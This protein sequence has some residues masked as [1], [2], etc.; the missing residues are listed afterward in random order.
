[1]D[2][3]IDPAG[4]VSETGQTER[5]KPGVDLFEVFETS[6]DVIEVDPLGHDRFRALRNDGPLRGLVELRIG[7]DPANLR[8]LTT[9]RGG[10]ADHVDRNFQ[11]AAEIRALVESVD[12]VA[13]LVADD[14]DHHVA[15]A[16]TGQPIDFPQFL[17]IGRRLED[18]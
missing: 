9:E 8:L 5:T 4:F 15:F 7:V 16:F 2:G 6:T 1:M 12:V 13:R 3:E 14:D 17:K 11:L 10:D 18:G